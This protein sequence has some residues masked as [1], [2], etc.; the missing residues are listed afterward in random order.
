MFRNVPWPATKVIPRGTT[1]LRH[2]LSFCSVF[3]G[4]IRVWAK[5]EKNWEKMKKLGR[6]LGRAGEIKILPSVMF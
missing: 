2:V 4:Y 5:M 6:G 3:R 1:G